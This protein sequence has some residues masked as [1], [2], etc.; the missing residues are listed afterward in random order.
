MQHYRRLLE[1][2]N[3]LQD[4][5]TKF[6]INDQKKKHNINKRKGMG[7]TDTSNTIVKEINQTMN[8]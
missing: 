1:N 4:V 2:E 8:Y 6:I 7:S 3:M 5:S